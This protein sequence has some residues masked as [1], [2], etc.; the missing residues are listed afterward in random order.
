M[1][2]KQMKGQLKEN[3]D[4]AKQKVDRV[5]TELNLTPDERR[6]LHDALGEDYLDYH[7]ILSRAKNMF[8]PINIQSKKGDN[9][10]W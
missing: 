9:K 2:D 1:S 7:D 10:R 5:V 8:Y 6:D 4:S 3:R